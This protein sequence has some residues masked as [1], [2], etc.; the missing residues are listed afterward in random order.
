LLQVPTLDMGVAGLRT[1][2]NLAVH[3]KL[4]AAKRAIVPCLL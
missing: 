4:R 2:K 3:I 1:G